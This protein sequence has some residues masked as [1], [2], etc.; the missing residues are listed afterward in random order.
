SARVPKD[1]AKME[2]LTRQ[3]VRDSLDAFIQKDAQFARH[4]CARDDAVDQLHRE[5]IKELR[6]RMHEKPE[7]IDAALDLFTV[8]R[9]LE[10]IA[11][12]ATNIAQD[13]VYMVQGE[14][15]RHQPEEMSAPRS[16]EA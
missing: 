14:I 5:I 6:A 2:Q 4:I 15:I 7:E 13:V 1:L 10:R 8:T 12:L 16:K 11:D 3:M 9:R